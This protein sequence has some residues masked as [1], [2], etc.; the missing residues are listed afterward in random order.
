MT[1]PMP[2]LVVLLCVWSPP[3]PELSIL[4]RRVLRLIGLRCNRRQIATLVGQTTDRVAQCQIELKRRAR[5][6]TLRDLGRWAR[7]A[8]FCRA[9]DRLSCLDQNRLLPRGTEP[10]R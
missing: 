4:E 8:D 1:G 10:G 2:N 6:A 3:A 7:T 9:G 5:V